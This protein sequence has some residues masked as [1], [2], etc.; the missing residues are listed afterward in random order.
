MKKWAI[1]LIHVLF[2]TVVLYFFFFRTRLPRQIQLLYAGVF[3]LVNISAFYV[4]LLFLLPLFFK[5]KKLWLLGLSW[6]GLIILYAAL[7][8]Y[9]TLI[10]SPFVPS[11]YQRHVGFMATLRQGG[12][13]TGFFIFIS[14]IY[15]LAED[16]FLNENIRNKLEK[17]KLKAELSFLRSQINP[18]FL[19]NTLNNI[20]TLAYQKSDKAPDAIGKLSAIMRYMLNESMDAEVPLDKELAYIKDF[21][22]LQ[23]L[24]IKDCLALQMDVSGDTAKVWIA[25]L[26]LINFLENAFKHGVLNDVNHP[27]TVKVNAEN[28]KVYF[29]ITNKISDGNKDGQKGIGLT[30]VQRRLDLLYPRRHRLEI[31]CDED[32]YSV[33]LHLTAKYLA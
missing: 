27:V 14:T 7:S 17:E 24:R 6:I 12:F 15:K 30:N 11:G 9:M 29:L 3:I 21:I 22:N 20:Y 28:D 23:Q 19:F 32:Q 26:I 18:H 1:I 33:E 13:M 16:W 2:W 8:N 4:N 5:R 25:P 10:L 31:I